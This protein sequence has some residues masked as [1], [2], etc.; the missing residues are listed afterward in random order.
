MFGLAKCDAEGNGWIQFGTMQVPIEAD[1]RDAASQMNETAT[2]TRRLHPDAEGIAEAARLLGEGRLVAFPTETVYGLAGDAGNGAAVAAIFAAKGRPSFN[3]L[4]VHVPDLD[5]AEKLGVFSDSARALA[6]AHW[7]GALTLV[8]PLR[9]G[10]GLSSLVSA[11]LD[12]VALRVPASAVALELLRVFGGPLAGPS[13]NPSGRIS[14]VTAD[15]VLLGLGGRIAAVLDGGRT[16]AGLESTIVSCLGNEPVILREGVVDPE[17]P[18]IGRATDIGSSAPRAPG[19][20]V[21]HYAPRATVRLNAVE[22]R[23]GETLIGFGPV[24]GD[25][26]L[27]PSG[28]VNEAAANLFACLHEMDSRGIEKLAVAPIPNAGIGRAI[29]DRLSRAAAPRDVV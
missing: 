10:S 29:N 14:P 6:R 8:V 17:W 25:V 2:E 12:S 23:D 1:N 18:E 22:A 4:I 16:A 11:G 27:S 7:P 28:D 24:A 26:S 3:P 5:T 21:S 20:L 19:Q 9:E 13:A 15:H